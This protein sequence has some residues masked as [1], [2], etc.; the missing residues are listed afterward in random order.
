MTLPFE[1]SACVRV[2]LCWNVVCV[3]LRVVAV[4]VRLG[5][6]FVLFTVVRVL[7]NTSVAV[8]VASQRGDAVR[9]L[10]WHQDHNGCDGQMGIQA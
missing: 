4:P 10:G 3:S 6:S 2:Q 9:N 7:L 5:C 1:M 8:C